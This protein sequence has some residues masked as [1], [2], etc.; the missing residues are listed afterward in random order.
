MED[1][2]DVLPEVS[3]YFLNENAERA[4]ILAEWILASDILYGIAHSDQPQPSA[5][6]KEFAVRLRTVLKINFILKVSVES[7]ANINHATRLRSLV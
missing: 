6:V 1:M 4:L 5:F 3:T 2:F 7:R